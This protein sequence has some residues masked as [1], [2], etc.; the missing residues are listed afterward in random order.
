MRN[1]STV[2]TIAVRTA[3]SRISPIRKNTAGI[4]VLNIVSATIAIHAVGDSSRVS[5]WSLSASSRKQI[6]DPILAYALVTATGC[7]FCIHCMSGMYM[8]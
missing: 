6:A 5:V 8:P 1:G 3:P 7:V 4:T 2:E